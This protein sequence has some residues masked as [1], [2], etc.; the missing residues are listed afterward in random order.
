MRGTAKHLSA[1]CAAAYLLFTSACSAPAA[2]DERASLAQN[3]KAPDCP[4]IEIGSFR[5]ISGG[6]LNTG[7]DAR[8]PEEARSKSIPVAG[9]WMA[10][11]EVTVGEF[12]EFVKATGYVTLA[13][14]DPPAL[15]DAPP[16]MLQAGSAVFTPPLDGNPNWWRW[17]VGANWR[18]PSGANHPAPPNP[19]EPVVHIAYEDAQAYAAWKGKSLPSEDQ[20]EWAARSAG[21]DPEAPPSK[22]GK[23][24]A[25][26]YQGSF[27]I[28]NDGTDG[29][30]SRAPVGCF[31]ADSK[32][33]YDMIGN[34]W[35]W[36]SAAEDAERNIIKG[37][38][39]LCAANYCARYR[40]AARQFQE[41]SLGTDH[42]G[43]RLI[44]AARPAPTP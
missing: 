41:R 37:G 23:P 22:A 21:H 11:H 36:T 24:S 9:F 16:E 27:P 13:E 38:S 34:V 12:A 26:V 19:R 42:I 1:A 4:Q 10:T 31:A 39:Y 5:W 30:L 17:V 20:W 35:E 43:F 2:E 40:P 29:Y 44:D 15:P 25:N 33:L 32:G 28:Q 18:Q 6:T 3:S 7:E 14:R 8:L